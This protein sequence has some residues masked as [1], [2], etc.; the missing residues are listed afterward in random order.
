MRRRVHRFGHIALLAVALAA[1]RGDRLGAREGR[2]SPPAA[3]GAVVRA[4][5]DRAC[6][7]CHGSGKANGGLRVDVAA[8]LAE[9]V[10]PGRPGD[11]LLVQRLLGRNGEDRMPLDAAPL[12]PEA[13][14]AVRRWI[15]AGAPP[16][17]GGVNAGPTPGDHWAY[18]P[19]AR[20]EPP[21]GGA[22]WARNPVD[23]FAFA[24]M[25][26]AGL[27]P[28]GEADRRALMRRVTLDLVGL[29]PTPAELEAFASD[30]RPDAYERLVDRLLASPAYGERW[31]VPWLDAARYADTNGFEKD[32]RRSAWPYRDWVV[33]ALNQDMPFD[34]FTREQLAGDLTGSPVATGFLRASMLNEEGGVDPAS[35]R[36]EALVDRTSTVATVWLGS[37]LGCA[38]CH[39]HK[40]DPFTQRDFYALLALFEA[41][42]DEVLALPTAQQAP[43]LA[44]LRRELEE[45]EKALAQASPVE[46]AARQEWERELAS[47]DARWTALRPRRVVCTNGCRA[48]V[49][50]HEIVVAEAPTRAHTV[51]FELSVSHARALRF[52]ALPDPTLPGGGPGR[53][54]DGNFFLEGLTIERGERGRFRPVALAAVAADDVPREEPERNAAQNLLRGSDPRVTEGPRGWGVFA[55]YDGPVRFRRQLVVQ[56]AAPLTGEVRVRLAYGRA[57][58][59][60]VIGRLRVGSTARPDALDAVVVTPRQRWVAGRPR[61]ARDAADEAALRAAFRRVSPTWAPARARVQELRAAID[62]LAVPSTLVVAPSPGVAATA[63]RSKGAFDRKGEVV[64]AR[65]PAAWAGDREIL[66]ADRRGLAA[67][68]TGSGR[69]LTARVTVNRVWSAHFGRGLVTTEDDFGTKGAAPTDPAL[70]DWLARSFVEGGWSLK[71]LHRTV[72]TSA[73]YR[74]QALPEPAAAWTGPRPQPLTAEMVR[75]GVLAA[76]GLLDERVGGPPAFPPQPAGLWA[77]PNSHDTVWPE[78]QG[79]DAYRRSLYTFWRRT[80][81]YPTLALLGAPSRETCTVRRSRMAGPLEALVTLNDP[82]L[83]RAAEALAVRARGLA[84][85]DERWIADTFTAATSRPPNA[86]EQEILRGLLDR[87]RARLRRAGRRGDEALRAADTLVASAVFNSAGFLVRP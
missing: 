58:S 53:G 77:L 76:A 11:S 50:G 55:M 9:V 51:S 23:A 80:A 6:L 84:P 41:S 7:S 60:E 38:R 82:A 42:R 61:A 49:S 52:E 25:K 17:P 43:Q 21:E 66:F 44:A 87:E 70:L 35:A 73:T 40:H 54:R 16:L 47:E 85:S 29:P 86:R 28:A 4:V 20:A 3:S 18:R 36:F 33:A 46:A 10:T 75:D 14:D 63:V 19:L 68:I 67:W 72:V 62:A 5:F 65:V 30:A 27:A 22:G 83:W 2:G 15:A 26:A 69:A 59:G 34:V 31:A 79:A 71:A 12:P 81:P 32:A 56:P 57:S 74:Q 8:S 48:A 45:A 39:D 1:C 24:R 64:T 37:T 13:V 78:S